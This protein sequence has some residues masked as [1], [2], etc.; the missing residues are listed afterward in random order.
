MAKQI[1]GGYNR[2]QWHKKGERIGY[3]ST[4]GEITAPVRKGRGWSKRF[5]KSK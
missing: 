5:K 2:R 3:S 4:A 1:Q